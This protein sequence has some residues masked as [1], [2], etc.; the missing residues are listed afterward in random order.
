MMCVWFGLV[1]FGLV[2]FGEKMMC[3]VEKIMCGL[4]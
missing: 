4:V 3:L 2:E 1:W